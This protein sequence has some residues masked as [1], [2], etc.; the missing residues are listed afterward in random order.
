MTVGNKKEDESE[1][2]ISILIYRL[3]KKPDVGSGTCAQI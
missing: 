2:S 3:T 1:K